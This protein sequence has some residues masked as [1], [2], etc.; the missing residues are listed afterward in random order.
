MPK[1]DD[2]LLSVEEAQQVYS[3]CEALKDLGVTSR[4]VY[5]TPEMAANWLAGKAEHPER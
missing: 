3:V 5:V 2:G 4:K 1:T